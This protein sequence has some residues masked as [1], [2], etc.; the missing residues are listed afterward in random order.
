[1]IK[2]DQSFSVGG[3]NRLLCSSLVL[4]GQSLAMIVK[5]DD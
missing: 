5:I 2:L 3:A 1:V 4:L